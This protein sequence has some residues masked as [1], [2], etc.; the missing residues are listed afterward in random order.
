ME[1]GGKTPT[2]EELRVWCRICDTEDQIP[3]LIATVRSIHSMYQEF[4]RQTHAFGHLASV[5]LYGKA[6]RQIITSVAEEL[7]SAK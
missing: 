3:D 1:H 4:R 6:A 2:E 7:S 5:A